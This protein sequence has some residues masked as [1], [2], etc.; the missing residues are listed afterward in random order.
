MLMAASRL[1]LGCD[2]GLCQPFAQ[3]D[4]GLGVV[5]EAGDFFV[6]SALVHGYGDVELGF[7]VEVDPGVAGMCWFRDGLMRADCSLSG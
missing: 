7:G 2:S 4:G 6:A 5:V 1:S 3:E